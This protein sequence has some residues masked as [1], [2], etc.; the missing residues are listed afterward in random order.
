M[1]HRTAP[2]SSHQEASRALQPPGS[3]AALETDFGAGLVV[4]KFG[5]SSV[6]TAEAITRVARR[7]MDTYESGHRVVVV[8]SAMGDTTDDLLDL[9][10]QVAPVPAARELDLLLTTGERISVAL[11]A[12]ALANLGAVP[13]TFTG[14]KTGL[15]TDEVHGKAHVVDVDARRIRTSL[16]RGEIPIVAGFQ[17]RSYRT[18]EI[19][20]LGRGGSD[21]TAIALA[22]ALNAG[23]CEIYTDVDGVYTADPRVVPTA[24]KIDRISSEGMLE[25]AANGAKI[26]HV[27][28]VE[29]ARR[30]GVT[31]HVRSSFAPGEGTFVVPGARGPAPET[32]RSALEDPIISDITVD[33][34]EAKIIIR[35]VADVPAATAVLYA[36]VA[37]AKSNVNIIVETASES[38]GGYTDITFTVP[39]AKGR[40]VLKLLSKLRPAARFESLVYDDQVGQLCL[41]GY[42]IRRDPAVFYR[43]CKALADAGINI[44]LMSTSEFR[45]NAV[46]RAHLLDDAAAAVNLAFGRTMEKVP[47]TQAVPVP[48]PASLPASADAPLFA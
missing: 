1:Y 28:C 29:Y 31:L 36:A 37:R 4:Q 27:R 15:V 47:A 12:L 33:R 23:V 45:I 14:A 40:A 26:L 7:I 44:E 22:S 48:S 18:R 17:G 46:V 32:P 11:L 39:A 21:I 9:A 6:A 43:F 19:T 2:A 42:G 25:L 35:G 30:F 10:A 8:V 20:T 41:S 38:A 13:H 3:P 34:L 5:G 24:R 16:S